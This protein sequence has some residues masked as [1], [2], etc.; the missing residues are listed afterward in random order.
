MNNERTVTITADEFRELYDAFKALMRHLQ[1]YDKCHKTDLLSL[2]KSEST[3]VDR[4]IAELH[5]RFPPPTPLP[6]PP[7]T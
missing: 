2:V 6:L 3:K 1:R 4:V 5:C 7:P